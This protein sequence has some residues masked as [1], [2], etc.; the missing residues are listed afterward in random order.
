V[1]A[2]PSMPPGTLRRGRPGKQCAITGAVNV[3]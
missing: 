3:A 2:R 1:T